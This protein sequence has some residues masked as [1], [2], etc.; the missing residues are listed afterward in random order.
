[1]T[2]LVL[3]DAVVAVTGGGR[4][5][6]LATAR[7]F[8]AQGARVF[9]GDLDEDAAKTAAAEFG[10]H[11]FAL[12]VR[13]KASFAAFLDSVESIGGPLTVLVN[14]A[15]IMPVGRLLDEDDAV[16][17]AIIDINLRGVLWGM[18]L[19]LPGM[20][21]RGQGHLV[22]VASYL[23]KV[24]AAGL[25]T[26]CASKY[27]VV[28]LSEAAREELAGTGV[29]ISAVL[30]SAVRTQLSDGIKLGGILPTVDP[31][32]I[33][34]AVLDSCRHRHAVIP[35]PGWM[36]A[37][38]P[39]AALTPY[40]LLS[41]LRGRLTRGRALNGVDATARADYNARLRT[42]GDRPAN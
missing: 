9:I 2:A 20:V 1:M 26:Y 34:A 7:A 25:A 15:G 35:V 3:T 40:S 27:G 39:I 31:E 36:R 29:S 22:N 33:A 21:A 10:G 38:E 41:A 13:S 19:A 16:T 32:E 6:G 12:D 28:G 4:G 14:N 8:A 30:P 5:I 37:Y 23:G 24:P 11:G 17:E 42:L 18:K